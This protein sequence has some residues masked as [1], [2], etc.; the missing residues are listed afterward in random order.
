MNSK[1]VLCTGKAAKMRNH[2]QN[3]VAV[4]VNVNV[5]V[6]VN[7]N[8]SVD[9]NVHDSKVDLENTFVSF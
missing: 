7:I 8:V 2:Q 4:V 9:V 1:C 3:D 6:D 5:N